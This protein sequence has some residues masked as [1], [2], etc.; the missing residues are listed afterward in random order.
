M[1]DEGENDRG[2]H[3]AMMGVILF[4]LA[5][6]S[7]FCLQTN[8]INKRGREIKRKSSMSFYFTFSLNHSPQSLSLDSHKSPRLH[9][10][11]YK[12][13][14]TLLAYNHLLTHYQ[15]LHQ[16]QY[17]PSIDPSIFWRFWGPHPNLS[18]CTP[19][20][21]PNSQFPIPLWFL[22]NSNLPTV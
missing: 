22:Q 13:P 12:R 15:Y 11:H 6:G 19:N 5:H 10:N 17:H 3:F 16:H 4:L 21:F 7:S 20:Q 1:D 18:F 8:A 9:H 14:L 2:A